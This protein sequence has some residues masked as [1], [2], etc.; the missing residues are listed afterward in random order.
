MAARFGTVSPFVAVSVLLDRRH[1]FLAERAGAR[2]RRGLRCMR[3]QYPNRRHEVARSIATGAVG[4]N[5]MLSLVTWNTRACA[6]RLSRYQRMPMNRRQRG[7]I[8]T[9]SSSL[10]TS[11]TI[12]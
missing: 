4:L 6:M 12:T 7:V 9:G 5:M 10:R 11:I 1:R 8:V 3:S 2:R